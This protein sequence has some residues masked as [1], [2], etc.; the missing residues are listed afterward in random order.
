MLPL[1]HKLKAFLFVFVLLLFIPMGVQAQKKV[2]VSGYV[3]DRNG[4]PIEFANVKVVGKPF[5]T[6]TDLKGYYK[7]TIVATRDSV[8]IEYSCLGFKSQVKKFGSLLSNQKINVKLSTTDIE[9]GGVVV[10]AEKKKRTNSMQVVKTDLAKIAA[11]PNAGVESLVGTYAGVSQ[12]NEL[13]SQYSVR[14]GSYDENMVYVNGIE[15]YR[16]LLVRTAEQEGLSFINPDLTGMVQF[17]A[18]GFTADYGDKISSVLDIKYKRP[19]KTEGSFSLGLLGGSA[20]VGS[21]VGKLSFIGGVRYKSGQTLLKNLNDTD[22]EY[23]PHYVDAQTYLTYNVSTHL[24]ASFLGNIS[25]TSYKFIPKTRETNFGTLE[26]TK[27]FKIYFDGK[28]QDKFLTLFGAFSLEHVPSAESRRSLTFSFFKTREQETYDID[29][30]YFLNDLGAQNP[31]AADILSGEG[32]LGIGNSHEHA[33]NHLYASVFNVV[34]RQDHVLSE[35]H[36]LQYGLDYK[37]EKVD[38]YINEWEK[39]D[40]MGY[41][42]PR[43]DDMVTVWKNLYSDASVHTSRFGCY[44]Q[45][46][47]RFTTDKGL[48][49]FTPGIRASYWSFNK[50]FTISP[51]FNGSFAPSNNSNL[52]F[53]LAG[54]LY[55]QAPFYKELRN[56]TFDDDGNRIV[57][58]NKD[59]KSQ[60]AW[61]ILAGTDVDFLVAD[62]KFK[63]TAELYYKYLFRINP[64]IRENVKIRYYGSNIGNGHVAGLDLKLFGEFVPGVDSWLT[65]SFLSSGQD[66]R[67]G[68]GH[69]PLMNAPKYNISLFFQDYFPGNNRISLS[70]RGVLSGGLPII[71]PAKGFSKPAFTASA[72][73]RIDIGMQYAIFE[74][75]DNNARGFW[76]NFRKI[77]LGLDAFN[78]FDISNV[79]SY[80]WISDVF[81]QQYAVPNYLTRRQWNLRMTVDF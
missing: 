7:F 12:N 33:R 66:L 49:T 35:R 43:V 24:R 47:I 1:Y 80:Y 28:E 13:S 63:F 41:S 68:L 32:V 69:M 22:A 73:K 56:E 77:T 8:A 26:N 55:Y 79:N 71:N 19:E 25:Y 48:F 45:D 42:L 16:P 78:L 15:V 36:R 58:L 60:G 61:T 14:G 9:L 76:S 4:E 38:D 2:Q 51:R 74:R 40:S 10:S 64:Y 23:D 34:Y 72:Y 11:S 54:G 29:G 59:I 30:S 39:R 3:L 52:I 67:N 20:Y 65:C 27:K 18:G 75:D 5:G 44:L 31:S 6:S 21:K 17:S 53:R 81:S 50:E 57:V 37:L 62:R 46:H 70:L